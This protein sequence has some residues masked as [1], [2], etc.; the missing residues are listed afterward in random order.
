MVVHFLKSSY[1]ERDEGTLTTGNGYDFGNDTSFVGTDN[2]YT[3]DDELILDE[4]SLGFLESSSHP[5]APAAGTTVSFSFSATNVSSSGVT[6]TVRDPS[7]NNVD[8]Y[9]YRR[10]ITSDGS[11]GNS[12][13][14]PDGAALIRI[15]GLGRDGSSGTGGD[16]SYTLTLGTPGGDTGGGGGNRGPTANKDFASTPK[17]Q[18][19]TINVLANDT[20]P[21][22]DTL[23]FSISTQTAGHGQI[24]VVNGRV[25][26]QPD[27]GFVGVDSFNYGISD[28][29]SH[30]AIGVVEVTVTGPPDPTVSSSSVSVTEG[31]AGTK[32]LRFDVT[33]S[34]SSTETV[35]VQYATQAD[36]TANTATAG[37]D[38]EATNGTLTFAPG[39]TSKPIEVVIRGD[40]TP[41]N[42]ETFALILSNP[43][44][45][46]LPG[47]MSSQPYTGT[48]TDDDTVPEPT[49]TMPNGARVV[50]DPTGHISGVHESYKSQSRY[51]EQSDHSYDTESGVD[52]GPINRVSLLLKLG[53]EMMRNG[54]KWIKDRAQTDVLDR[55]NAAAKDI[56]KEFGLQNALAK[57]FGTKIDHIEK[58]TDDAVNPDPP[59]VDGNQLDEDETAGHEQLHDDLVELLEDEEEAQ[60]IVEEMDFGV[61]GVD[62]SA[63]GVKS[64]LR[65]T[66][67]QTA[68]HRPQRSPRRIL[69]L[70]QQ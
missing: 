6:V 5:R 56:S 20:D 30:T 11:F 32:I 50:Q 27:P 65:F 67:R 39:E 14:M 24:S 36:G 58:Y 31:D 2:Y 49:S 1:V 37:G 28:G 13:R 40:Y 10:T 64:C 47:G 53:H 16:V 25:V 43:S 61:V 66:R 21:D 63:F 59:D 48:I 69:W 42:N 17:N 68:D 33:L 3:A 46:K 18:A 55:L 19:V 62:H 38:Y 22:N 7:S 52:L 60:D 54:V 45:A 57:F 70:C 35:T 23:S 51:V 44:N 4:R 12:F 8:S 41:E 29:H 15:G 26:Y 9:I 34:A